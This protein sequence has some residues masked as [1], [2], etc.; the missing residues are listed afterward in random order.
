MK[1]RADSHPPLWRQTVSR[2]SRDE[3]I[4]WAERA[5]IREYDGG[6]ARAE[7]ERAAFDDVSRTHEA[8]K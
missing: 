2:W 7:A 6:M 1:G 8:R 5:A 4:D 3:Q